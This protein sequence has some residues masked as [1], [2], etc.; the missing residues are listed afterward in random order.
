MS[1][2]IRSDLTEA[3]WRALKAEAATLGMPVALF[4]ATI[5][6]AYLTAKP[7]RA[8]LKGAKP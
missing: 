4:T 2:S 6:R 1:K 3:E 5:F 7:A 8:L